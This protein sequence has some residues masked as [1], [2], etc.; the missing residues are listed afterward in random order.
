[1]FHFNNN[2]SFIKIHYFRCSNPKVTISRPTTVKYSFHIFGTN[3]LEFA[4]EIYVHT[5]TM[6]GYREPPAGCL[7]YFM[8]SIVINLF[9]LI[10]RISAQDV[11][12]NNNNNN[13]TLP[14]SVHRFD[15]NA[16]I[17]IKT[18]DEKTSDRGLYCIFLC[19]QILI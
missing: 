16:L 13:S 15:A 2:F 8:L 19:I 5:M 4:G 18:S 12:N 1:M 17:N 10:L 9:I 3:S 14:T 11:H 6:I 7:V